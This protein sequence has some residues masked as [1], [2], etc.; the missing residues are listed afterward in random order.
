MR[1]FMT[2]STGYIGSAVVKAL[3]R[4]GHQVSGLVRTAEREAMLGALGGTP[5]RGDLKDPSTY[6]QA[7]AEHDVSVHIALFDY[8]PNGIQA[9]RRATE[10]LLEA[11]QGVGAPRYM[12]YTSG[13]LV[14]GHT[15]DTPVD[16]RA[17]TA[18]AVPLVAWRPAHE[19]L[20]LAAATETFTTAVIR[21]GFVYGG[22]KGIAAGY[23]ES[24]VDKGA[25]AYVGDGK[26]RMA[27]VHR[28][29]LAEL[30]RLLVE[31]RAGGMFHGVDGAAPSIAE[32]ARAASGAAGRG[33]ATRSLPVEE[34]RK[35][36]GSLADAL[37]T[38]Q[39][40]AT[41]QAPAIGWATS[42]RPFVEAAQEMF[43]EWQREARGA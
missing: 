27:L 18:G 41:R 6:R 31:K 26:N 1:V 38:D 22:G 42:H 39:V 30:Y 2:G 4:K 8:G 28:D 14:L 9:D 35:T 15:G 19:Q 24:A 21:P 33:G 37:G 7:A 11:T 40:I 12:L 36:M 23:F 32:L 43:Q 17:S 3:V 29:D 13:V 16:E 25:A 10:T 20:V 34:A 5:V